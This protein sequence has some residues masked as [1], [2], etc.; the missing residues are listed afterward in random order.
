MRNILILALLFM[1][2][3]AMAQPAVAVVLFLSGTATYAPSDTSTAIVLKPGQQLREGSVLRTGPGSRLRL[4]L[5]DGTSLALGATATLRLE[6]LTEPGDRRPTRFMHILGFLR[7]EAAPQHGAGLEIDSDSVVAAVRGTEWIQSS[8]EGQTA[9]FTE[10]GRVALRGRGGPV[11]LTTGR[12][13]T[14]NQF[15]RHTP[16]DLWD[17]LKIIGFQLE[18]ELS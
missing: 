3:G 9:I 17:V 13:V 5:S 12:G 2:H 1:A 8:I 7:V 4:E 14:F 15:E 6:H 16:I 11:T 18:T 10:S